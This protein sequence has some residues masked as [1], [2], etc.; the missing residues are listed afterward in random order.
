[1]ISRLSARLSQASK[2]SHNDLEAS[3]D[4]YIKLLVKTQIDEKL[5]EVLEEIDKKISHLQMPL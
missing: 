3:E 5:E 1:M 4:E 2:L